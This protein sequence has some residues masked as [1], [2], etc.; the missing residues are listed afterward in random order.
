VKE[1]LIELNNAEQIL[2]FN[3]NRFDFKVLSHYGRIK[4][5]RT[6]SVDLLAFIKKHTRKRVSLDSIA[7]ENLG[8]KKSMDGIEAVKLWRTGD[9]EKQNKV[10]EYC[11]GDVAI[12]R[13]LYVQ[14]HAN[15]LRLKGY[16]DEVQILW[17]D[18]EFER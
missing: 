5:L 12:L 11:K 8:I 15:C 17:P 10:I 3:G 14:L 16:H 4:Y 9:P 13:D 6:K 1:L 2:T 18:G 7:E